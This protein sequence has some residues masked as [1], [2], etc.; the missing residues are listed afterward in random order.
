MQC[1]LWTWINNNDAGLMVIVTCIY[2]AITIA[3]WRTSINQQR[4]NVKLSLID[5]KMAIATKIAE[6]KYAQAAFEALYIFD[7]AISDEVG[8]TASI[9]EELQNKEKEIQDFFEFVKTADAEYYNSIDVVVQDED[10]FINGNMIFT[11]E[12]S[13]T[14][15]KRT[16]NY[17]EALR[18]KR[19]IIEKLYEQK[20]KVLV[21]IQNDIK[22]CITMK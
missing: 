7:K 1:N 20:G 22:T 11:C 14:G 3:M 6:E 4:Q 18:E 12:N 15:E 16:L 10:F 2:A 17:G 19:D 8:K 21:C 9:S 5:K 13:C